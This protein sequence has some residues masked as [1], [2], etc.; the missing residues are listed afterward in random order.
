MIV[1]DSVPLPAR[2]SG[3][4]QL[5][6]ARRDGLPAASGVPFNCDVSFLAR[7]KLRRGFLLT[8]QLCSATGRFFGAARTTRVR[9]SLDERLPFGALRVVRL[10]VEKDCPFTVVAY[11]TVNGTAEQG[12]RAGV[13]SPEQNRLWGGEGSATFWLL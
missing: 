10:L 2:R 13:P 6:D 8:W 3:A 5:D 9:Q 11:R 7:H 1:R 4:P 12:E